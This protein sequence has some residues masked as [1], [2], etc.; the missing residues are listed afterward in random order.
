MSD[1]NHFEIRSLVLTVEQANLTTDFYEHVEVD[2]VPIG[3]EIWVDGNQIAEG[4]VVDL[5]GLLD[6]THKLRQSVWKTYWGPNIFTCGCGDPGCADI[7]DAIEVSH[8]GPLVIWRANMQLVCK[9]RSAACPHGE[10]TTFRFLKIQMVEQCQG[11]VSTARVVSGRKLSR[12]RVPVHK[13]SLDSL[14]RKSRF[15]WARKEV[16]K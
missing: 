11:F 3:M 8:E 12:V 9:R 7:N 13:E 1:V 4:V 16:G 6:T 2:T 15:K 5:P 14:L 10:V